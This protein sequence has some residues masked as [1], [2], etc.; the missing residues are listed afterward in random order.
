MQI[1][2][3]FPQKIRDPSI[4]KRLGDCGGQPKEKVHGHEQNQRLEKYGNHQENTHTPKRVFDEHA[5][6]YGKIEP[7]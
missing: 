1:F 5:P 7:A 3:R 6:R 2:R 4:P